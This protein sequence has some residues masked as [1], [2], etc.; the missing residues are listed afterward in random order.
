MKK[1]LL[2]RFVMLGVAAAFIST[3]VQTY[4]VPSVEAKVVTDTF[5]FQPHRGGRDARPENTL[6]S[7]AYAMEMGATSIECDMQMTKDGVIVM[8]HNPILN[9]DITKDK[10]GNYVEAGKYDIRTMTYKE[11]QKFTV[12]DIDPTSGYYEGHGKTQV[13]FN[14]AKIPT[15]EELFQLINE[16]GDKKVIVNAETK[17]N[18]D[19]AV[20]AYH[21]NDVDPVKF[22]TEVNRLVKKYNM[23]DRF[24]LQSFDWRT[25]IEMKKIN[26]NITLVA[27]WCQQPSWGRDSECLRPYEEGASPWLG[28][29]DIDDFKGNPYQAAKS[30]GADIVSPY[31]PEISLENVQETHALGMKIVPWTINDAVELESLLNMGV[32]GIITDKPWMAR[33]VLEKRG[34]K[35]NPPTVNK[36]SK[37]HSGTAHIDVQTKR[38]AGGADASH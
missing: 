31:G 25:L 4:D 11:L 9:H 10:N 14:D 29:I 17:T 7:Y 33:E 13:T 2:K 15:L 21:A 12:G 32:D 16:Y 20:P 36:D 19:P 23:E 22:V 18:P 26:P 28:G 6:Y 5:D 27:L 8:S 38:L 24:T 34:V 35:L 3:G 1:S 37:Y 30:I